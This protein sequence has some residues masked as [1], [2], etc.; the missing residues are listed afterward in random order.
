MNVSNYARRILLGSSDGASQLA[1]LQLARDIL[2]GSQL[3]VAMAQS[4]DGAKQSIDMGVMRQAMALKVKYRVQQA[5][6]SN[7]ANVSWDL[8]GAH[9]DNRGASYPA[10]AR[11]KS[12]AASIISM[13]CSAEEA[14]HMG[15]VVQE[16]PQS[17]RLDEYNRK[18][19]KGDA[20]LENCFP[21]CLQIQ[22]GFLNHTHFG[23][24]M[25]AFRGKAPW[26][27]PPVKLPDGSEL[28]FCDPQGRLSFDLLRDNENGKDFCYLN[29]KGALV[30][31]L[32]YQMETEEPTA[33][34]LISRAMNMKQEVA[35][36]QTEL[37]AWEALSGAIALQASKNLNARVS[38]QTV[39]A[40]VAADLDMLADDPDLIEM[41]DL[42]VS[43]GGKGSV[44]LQEIQDWGARFVDQKKRRMRLAGFKMINGMHDECPRA[45]VAVFKYTYKGDPINGFVRSPDEWWTRVKVESMA[46]FEACLHYFHVTCRE[47]I[48]QLDSGYARALYLA[49]VDCSMAAAFRRSK[50]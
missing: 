43:L 1:G 42:I 19:T 46:K 45:K 37:Q 44:Y 26:D 18:Q 49:G 11:V 9:P 33:A 31:I 34:K 17:R 41:F 4:N 24:I 10:G 25:K 29:D 6:G 28:P 50:R 32:A 13:G 14:D 15:V 2:V 12:L 40:A 21:C 22:F 36:Q 20:D 39:L 38:F 7:R 27:A 16:A 3:A 47:S 48:D 30:E 5:D 8:C 23:L 35:L